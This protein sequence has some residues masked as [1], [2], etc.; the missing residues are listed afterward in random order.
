MDDVDRPA[1]RRMWT[2]AVTSGVSLQW[3]DDVPWLV[4]TGADDDLAHWVADVNA[5]VARLC[6]EG[7]SRDAVGGA[8]DRL[9]MHAGSRHVLDEFCAE[10]SVWC[11]SVVS[12]AVRRV[13]ADVR[14]TNV[15]ALRGLRRRRRVAYR[16]SHLAG[17]SAVAVALG[18]TSTAYAEESLLTIGSITRRRTALETTGCPPALRAPVRT[19]LGELTAIPVRWRD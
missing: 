16:V 13:L 18:S 6:A 9:A 4:V 11:R 2:A 8:F 7:C 14:E 5:A 15:A 12:A 19:A 10:L 1:A 17:S 3:V